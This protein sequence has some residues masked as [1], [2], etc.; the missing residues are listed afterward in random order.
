[1]NLN[2]K[3]FSIIK[4]L[5]LVILIVFAAVYFASNYGDVEEV[6]KR[7]QEEENEKFTLTEDHGYADD[8]GIAYYIEGKVKNNT[9]SDYTYVQVQFN[10]YDE[11]GSIVGSC[12]DNIN[13]LEGYGTWKIKAICTDAGDAKAIKSYKLTG[14]TSW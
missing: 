8:Y 6:I 9:S 14:F 3:G 5:L 4:V 10:V 13:N 7:Q 12:L 2:N 1:M 11:N